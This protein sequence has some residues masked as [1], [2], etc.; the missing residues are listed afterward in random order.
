MEN[1]NHSTDAPEAAAEANMV[2]HPTPTPVPPEPAPDPKTSMFTDE[3]AASLNAPDPEDEV[4]DKEL[5][6]LRDDVLVDDVIAD[7][8]HRS[9]LEDG[10]NV[11][12][13]GAYDQAGLGAMNSAETEAGLQYRFV[14]MGDVVYYGD[15]TG[16]VW[17]ALVTHIY[18]M[19]VNQGA[20][21]SGLTGAVAVRVDLQVFKRKHITDVENVGFHLFEPP[22]SLDGWIFKA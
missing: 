18:D 21:P 8:E 10:M 7:S 17:P 16:Q 3:E 11:A 5:Q 4:T 9:A 1:S 6:Q 20:E 15:G 22:R 2:S 14:S 13:T 19:S 12:I